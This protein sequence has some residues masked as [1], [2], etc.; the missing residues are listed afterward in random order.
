MLNPTVNE[1]NIG[2]KNIAIQYF[3]CIIKYTL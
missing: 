2:D 1:I 3:N